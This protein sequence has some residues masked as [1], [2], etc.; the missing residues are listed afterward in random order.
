[1]ILGDGGWAFSAACGFPVVKGRRVDV[2]NLIPRARGGVRGLGQTTILVCGGTS[3]TISLTHQ[4]T[5]AVTSPF[6]V[7]EATG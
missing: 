3:D 2:L 5:P 4:S 6:S 1:M 7:V